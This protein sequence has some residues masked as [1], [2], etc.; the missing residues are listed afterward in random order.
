[1]R[2]PRGSDAP[3]LFDAY[4]QD[5]EVTRYMMWRPHTSLA[6]TASFVAA[7]IRDWAD[8]G[9]L[10]YILTLRD[11]PDRGIGVLD[12][13]LRAHTI[14]IGYVIARPHWGNGLMPEA[15]RA[16]TDAALGTSRFFRVQATCDVENRASARALEKAGFTR[17]GRLERYIVHPNI[18]AD[19]RPSF[20]YA[21]CR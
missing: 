8:G 1:L 4:T 20:L 18:Q 7:C 9:R 17:E 21:R 5:A 19:P 3:V 15:I 6:Q 11:S 2:E 16:L 12:A 10:P 13:K 14:D